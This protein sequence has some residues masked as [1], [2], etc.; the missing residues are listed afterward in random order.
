MNTDY[1]LTNFLQVQKDMHANSSTAFVGATGFVADLSLCSTGPRVQL[2]S[3]GQHGMGIDGLTGTSD[4]ACVR[5]T[6]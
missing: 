1:I 2:E 6:E 4:V 3:F 5:C